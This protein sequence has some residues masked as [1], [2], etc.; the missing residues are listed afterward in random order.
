MRR[1]V[2]VEFGS[3]QP[4]RSLWARHSTSG[5][6]VNSTKKNQ[7]SLT[8]TSAEVSVGKVSVRTQ[9]KPDPVMTGNVILT[10]AALQEVS[11]CSVSD[12]LLFL[13]IIGGYQWPC[14]QKWYHAVKTVARKK[15]IESRGTVW[16]GPHHRQSWVRS[17]R[18]VFSMTPEFGVIVC[19]ILFSDDDTWS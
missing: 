12:T 16:F 1:P 14:R 15:A 8:L 4:R 18:K 17:E 19:F 7:K 5:S 9:L 11:D 2:S 13:Y 10:D 3:S 6:P